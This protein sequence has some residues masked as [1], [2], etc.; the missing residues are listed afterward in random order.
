MGSLQQCSAPVG[1]NSLHPLPFII[2]A[3]LYFCC[4]RWQLL[5][6]HTEFYC[7]LSS[8]TCFYLPNWAVWIRHSF[9]IHH[10]HHR[11]PSTANTSSKCSCRYNLWTFEALEEADDDSQNVQR[12]QLA[13]EV[14]NF[15]CQ[16]A[17]LIF[18]FSK[19]ISAAVYSSQK[20]KPIKMRSRFE[21]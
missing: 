15:W 20:H 3:Y 19:K 12:N 6:L 10:F 9:T 14:Y 7:F 1:I 2:L 21:T 16:A 8:F 13:G 17:C 18:C 5:L 4:P 11:K